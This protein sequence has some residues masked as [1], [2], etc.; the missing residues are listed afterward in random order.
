MIPRTIFAAALLGAALPLSGACSPPPEPAAE[1]GQ[2][3]TLTPERAKE[4]LLAMMQ[5]KAGKSLGW[6]KGDIPQRMAKMPIEKGEDGWY[7]WT[8]A[9]IFH[10]AKA[11]YTFAVR[12]RPGVR[13]CSFEY[14]GSF[15]RKDGRWIATAPELVQTALQAGE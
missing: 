1:A 3:P 7:T 6:F 15:V 13:A 14:K 10:P 9:F 5:T 4:A 8:G 12:P 11:I 2:P